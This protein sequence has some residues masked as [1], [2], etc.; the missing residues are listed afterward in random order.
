MAI[1]LIQIKTDKQF[2]FVEQKYFCT[3]TIENVPLVLGHVDIIHNASW[4]KMRQL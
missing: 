4:P 1:L 2:L 3:N